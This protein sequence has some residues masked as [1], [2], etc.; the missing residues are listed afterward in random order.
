MLMQLGYVDEV[1]ISIL[2]EDTIAFDTPFVGRF[3]LSMLLELKAGSCE[4]HILFD[5]NS[6][7]EPILHNLN[8]MGKS[9][10]SVDTIF[11]SHCHYDHSDGLQGILQ[12]M[13][14]PVPVVAHCELFRPC[15]EINPDGIRHIGI[16]G[17]GRREL[18]QSRAIFTLT[19]APLNLMTGV[20]TSGEIERITSFEVLEDLY[21]IVDGKVVQDQERDDGALILNFKEGL[22]IITGCCHA[23]IVNTMNQAQK[24][25]GVEKIYAVIGGLHFQDASAEKIE[26]SIE[27]LKKVDWVFAGHCTGFEG[28]GRIAAAKGERFHPLHTGTMIHLPGTG[29]DPVVSTI[30]TAVRDRHRSCYEKAD[31]GPNL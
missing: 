11:L 19:Q 2:A 6:A 25:T 9:L 31:A 17:Q 18:E 20:T 13:G 16:V 15:F 21:T 8:I 29:L 3:G 27:A 26:K 12:A 22:V 24:I 10:E 14:R 5:T 1:L 7:A 28:M 23:G 30:S 4:K